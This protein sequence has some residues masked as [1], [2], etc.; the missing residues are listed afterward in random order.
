[1]QIYQGIQLVFAH[2]GQLFQSISNW[3]QGIEWN[4]LI[5]QFPLQFQAPITACLVILLALSGVGI[6]KKLSFLLG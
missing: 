2:V 3:F 4:I 5:V 1:M 6:I